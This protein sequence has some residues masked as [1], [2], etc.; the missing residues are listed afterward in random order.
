MDITNIVEHCIYCRIER[1]AIG[2]LGLLLLLP[3]FPYFRLYLCALFGFFGASTAAQ[4]IVLLLANKMYLSIEL[5]LASA[6]LIIIILQMYFIF[7]WGKK[8]TI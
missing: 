3:Y 8:S 2:L 1:T 5:P 4:H 6:A 7:Y